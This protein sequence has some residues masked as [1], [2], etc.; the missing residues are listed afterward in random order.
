MHHPRVDPKSTATTTQH[1]LCHG[2]RGGSVVERRALEGE[3]GSSKP[4][5]CVVSLGK[6]IYF[7]K[8]LVIHR[9]RWLRTDMTEK[10]LTWT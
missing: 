2:E 6:T 10:V 4:T 5:F 1:N 7:S 8:V 9:K 3:V